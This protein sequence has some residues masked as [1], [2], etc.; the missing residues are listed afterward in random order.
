[1]KDLVR[2][3]ESMVIVHDDLKEK[4]LGLHELKNDVDI[5]SDRLQEMKEKYK[6]FLI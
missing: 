3:N 1:M 6:V 5:M 4:I 2:L